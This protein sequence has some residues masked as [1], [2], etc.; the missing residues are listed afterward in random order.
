MNYKL[1]IHNIEKWVY[2]YNFTGKLLATII[3]DPLMITPQGRNRADGWHMPQPPPKQDATATLI[4]E[5]D[6]FDKVKYLKVET[7]YHFKIK[8]QFLKLL[9]NSVAT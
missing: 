4:S 6:C 1:H 2:K 3:Q 9:F 7:M 5:T 8:S